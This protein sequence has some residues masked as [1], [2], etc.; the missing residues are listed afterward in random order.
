MSAEGLRARQ[1]GARALVLAVVVASAATRMIAVAGSLSWIIV[2]VPASIETLMHQDR[3]A[4]PTALWCLVDQHIPD[5]TVEERALA[6][7][8]LASPRQ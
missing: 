1:A 3:G 8:E 6:G 2:G 4:L 7:V 5:R